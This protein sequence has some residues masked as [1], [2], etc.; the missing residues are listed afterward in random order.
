MG[1]KTGIWVRSIT[2][3]VKLAHR[4]IACPSYQRFCSPELCQVCH[5]PQSEDNPHLLRTLIMSRPVLS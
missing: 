2:P 3:S 5:M 4:Q 1:A